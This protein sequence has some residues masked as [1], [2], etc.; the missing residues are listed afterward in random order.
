M[1]GPSKEAQLLRELHASSERFQMLFESSSDLVCLVEL[2]PPHG[3]GRILD[4]N[5]TT[6]RWTGYSRAQLLQM[7]IKDLLPAERL[8]KLPGRLEK[9]LKRGHIKFE[10][11][12]LTRQGSQIPLLAHARLLPSADTSQVLLV[13]QRGEAPAGGLTAAGPEQA[14]YECDFSTGTIAWSG[15]TDTVL[16]VSNHELESFDQQAWQDQIH[17]E[18]RE[19][20]QA[21]RRQAAVDV[22]KYHVE[23]RLRHPDGQFRPVEDFGIILPAENGTASRALGAIRDAS[24]KREDEARR[25]QEQ[26]Q[27][28]KT[29]R[30]E[31]LGVLSSGIAHDFN[32]ILVGIIGLTDL[33]L[34]ELPQDSEVHA[35]LRE[36]LQAAHRAKELVEQILTFT[37]HAEEARAP[38]YLHLIVREALKLLRASLPSTISIIERV[39]VQSGTVHASASQMHQL[40]MNYCANAAQALSSAGGTIEVR[41]DDVEV[42]HDYAAQHP[43]LHAGPYVRL[44]VIDSGHGMSEEIQ[45]HIFE[46]F[47]TTREPGKGTGMGLPLVHGIV[48]DHGGAVVVESKPG[49]GAAF[50]TYLPRIHSAVAPQSP[51]PPEQAHG[52]ERVLFVDDE[53]T[54]RLFARKALPR[55]GYEVTTSKSGAEALSLFQNQPGRYDLL[56]TDQIMP[57]MTG[58]KLAKA[59]HHLRPEL[60]ILLFTGL[61]E[62]IKEDFLA[63]AGIVEVLMKPVVMH[64]LGEAMRRALDR[65][66]SAQLR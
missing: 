12:L 8:L 47:F 57:S 63:E 56:I 28:E 53:E 4:A 3:S 27:Q 36:A 42:D 24:H 26:Q 2:P 19:R 48:S 9:L 11:R 45:A 31:S 17:P 20:V 37:R 66:K 35:D 51:A 34:R 1:A 65:P 41:V 25:R 52:T 6:C 58:D 23:Y 39:D 18:D 50:Y 40:V 7:Q 38:L 62:K 16:G 21:S 54:V 59:V 55:L 64:E 60:P 44:S 46:P 29:G 61:T 13:A 22:S 33:S 43:K 32:N 10:M 14:M 30:L 15:A 49:L 5:P